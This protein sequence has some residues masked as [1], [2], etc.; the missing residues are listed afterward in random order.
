MNNY[1]AAAYGGDTRTLTGIIELLTSIVGATIP[2][3]IALCLL[4]FFWGIAQSIMSANSGK[5]EAAAEGRSKMLWGV[6]ALFVI[7]SLAG[8]I[9]ILDSTFLK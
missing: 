3:A 5:A 1:L 7:F 8:L 2:I 4:V 9:N 6:I